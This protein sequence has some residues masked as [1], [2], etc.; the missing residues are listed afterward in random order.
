MWAQDAAAMYGY[1]GSSAPA[2]QLS[3]FTEPQQTTNSGGLTAQSAAVSQA[4]A[5]PAGLSK[6]PCPS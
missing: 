4:A 5:T 2:T 6:R 3:P 1:A